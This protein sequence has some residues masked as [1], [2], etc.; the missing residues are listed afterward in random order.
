VSNS[1]PAP[2]MNVIRQ[3]IREARQA[4]GFTQEQLAEQAGVSQRSISAIEK[5]SMDPSV[6]T[7][8]LI[9]GALGIG[10]G[11]YLTWKGGLT[12]E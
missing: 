10:L 2:D 9:L 6:K 7:L 11:L 4:K 1:V 3:Q 8:L 12:N 5:G